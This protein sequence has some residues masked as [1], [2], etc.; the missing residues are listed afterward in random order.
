MPTQTIDQPWFERPATAV[1][2]DLV[3]CCLVRQFADGTIQRGIIVET[4]AYEPGDPACHAYLRK[5]PR[6]AA[7]FGPAGS[8]YVYLI[9]SIYHCVNIVTEIEGVPS[10]VLI[11]A[12]DLQG[13]VDPSL[14][15]KAIHRLAAG[16][17]KLCRYL[18]IDRSLNETALV[19]GQPLWVEHRSL[20]YTSAEDIQQI[21]LVQ[22]T[23]IGLSQGVDLPWRWYLKGSPAVS[24]L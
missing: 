18:N 24:K 22:T 19:E 13:V 17:G 10:A 21:E 5:T 20:K 23:R 1:A 15:I 3:G 14:S 12:L 16:P 8:T 4:E 7:M 6:N 2:P 9:Y 11:R